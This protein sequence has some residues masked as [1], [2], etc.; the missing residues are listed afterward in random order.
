MGG[1]RKIEDFVGRG[2]RNG[3]GG[4]V[5]FQAATE[6]SGISSDDMT[7]GF[8]LGAAARYLEKGFSFSRCCSS[9]SRERVFP[10]QALR[11]NA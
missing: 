4:V 9:V 8:P 10:L 6:Q 2:G 5:A 1:P 7:E 11:C 3:A